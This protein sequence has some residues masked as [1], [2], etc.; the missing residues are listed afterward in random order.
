MYCSHA[1]ILEEPRLLLPAL[2]TIEGKARAVKEEYARIAHRAEVNTPPMSEDLRKVLDATVRRVSIALRNSDKPSVA[3]KRGLRSLERDLKKKHEAWANPMAREGY[4]IANSLLGRKSSMGGYR[5][6]RVAAGV[7]QFG[8][9]E[10]VA[11]QMRGRIATWINRT[12][13][14]ETRTTAKEYSRII[15]AAMATLERGQGV[16]PVG[17]ANEFLARG[18]ARNKPRA[19]LMARTATNW[20]YNRG[21]VL[22]FVDSGFST[23]EWL[24]TEDDATCEFCSAMDG[25]EFPI[26]GGRAIFK[27]GDKMLGTQGGVLKM[28]ISVAHPPLHPHCRCTIV[29]KVNL[30]GTKPPPKPRRRQTYIPPLLPRI[31]PGKKPKP[32]P[33]EDVEIE[34]E[35]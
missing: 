9:E 28:G 26:T 34:E 22:Q 33:F 20:S 17:L 32:I 5:G 15:R 24:T 2:P 31:K 14:I 25:T 12:S 18:L 19:T 16:T 27:P 7:E 11:V 8:A 1:Y 13:K 10:L 6:K 23:A 35:Y 3:V 30:K 4:R 21:A 29:P